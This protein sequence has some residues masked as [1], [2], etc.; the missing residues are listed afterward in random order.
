M[1]DK[2]SKLVY[3][4]RKDAAGV[5]DLYENYLRNLSKVGRYGQHNTDQLIKW[6]VDTNSEIK[7]LCE[8]A[9]VPLPILAGGALRDLVFN[10]AP[11]DYDYFFNCTSED[12]AYETID[13]LL[14]ALGPEGYA[15]GGPDEE[16]EEEGADF[17]GVYGVFNL[18]GS[19]AQI[20]VGVWP[21]TEHFFDRFDLSIC[22]AEMDLVTEDI[23]FS[24]AFM[25]TIVTEDIVRFR[26]TGYSRLRHD[27]I[28]HK[29]GL[30]PRKE[31]GCSHA[32]TAP[33]AT[34][35]I[36]SQMGGDIALAAELMYLP[37][38]PCAEII[39][40]PRKVLN[41]WKLIWELPQNP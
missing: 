20:I 34:P 26:D 41:E 38:N 25:E 14:Y 8:K 31:T 32:P 29:L 19:D 23:T 11:K 40:K 1:L 5:K 12:E 28:A 16:Y 30:N 6:V 24:P 13:K 10:R 7:N 33:Q 22:Q 27:N 9:N 39:M 21:K 37:Q 18:M 15:E 3:N 35:I 4:I 17:E 36:F 2:P